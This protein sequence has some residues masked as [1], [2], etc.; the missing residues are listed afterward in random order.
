MKNKDN[1]KQIDGNKEE[2][3]EKKTQDESCALKPELRKT[4]MPKLRN[5]PNPVV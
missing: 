2:E 4:N 1:V 5:S 3:K